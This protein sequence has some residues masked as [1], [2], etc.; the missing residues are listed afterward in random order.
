MSD[1]PP[2]ETVAD[3][4][5]SKDARMWATLAHLGGFLFFIPFLV[6][7]VIWLLKRDEFS[8]VDQQGKEALN[9][10]IVVAIGLLICTALYTVFCIGGLLQLVIVIADIILA[11]ISANKG[12]PYRYPFSIRFIK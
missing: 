6:P 5:P 4:L 1:L 12:E 2:N 9:F 10:Q 3:E 8:Y 7:L 11:A